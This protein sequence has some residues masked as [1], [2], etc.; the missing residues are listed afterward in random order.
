MRCSLRKVDKNLLTCS[1]CDAYVRLLKDLKS[2]R[3]FGGCFKESYYQ[4][5]A[6]RSWSLLPFKASSLLALGECFGLQ[7]NGSNMDT[8]VDDIGAA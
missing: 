2:V 3:E 5:P 1:D 6:V 8:N 7:S 4:R